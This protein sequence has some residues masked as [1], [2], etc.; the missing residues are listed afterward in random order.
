MELDQISKLPP[1]EQELILTG[2]ALQPPPGV[3]P[4]FQD[5]DNKDDVARAILAAGLVATSLAVFVR[6]Y[7]K[8]ICMK[9]VE[10]ED[11]EPSCIHFT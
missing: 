5:P 2:P 10:I 11:C 1:S 8:L 7:S 3:V 9:Q 6:A 4:N